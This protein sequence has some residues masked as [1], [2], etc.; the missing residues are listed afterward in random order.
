MTSELNMGIGNLVWLLSRPDRRW[1]SGSVCGCSLWTAGYRA[2]EMLLPCH[3]TTVKG[4]M[5]VIRSLGVSVSRTPYGEYRLSIRQEGGAYYTDD[6]EDAIATARDM[7]KR[8]GQN[9][10]PLRV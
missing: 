4:T 2:D 9:P 1:C 7:S 3:T 8:I 5:K 6:A 10:W